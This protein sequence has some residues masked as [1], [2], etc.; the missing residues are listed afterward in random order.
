MRDSDYGTGPVWAREEQLENGWGFKLHFSH[1][2]SIHELWICNVTMNAKREVDGCNKV[3]IFV[4]LFFG[5]PYSS[6]N[7]WPSKRGKVISFQ[8]FDGPEYSGWELSFLHDR[9]LRSSVR[10][11]RRAVRK[12]LWSL[13]WIHQTLFSYSLSIPCS[14]SRLC[15]EYIFL[16]RV[17]SI[18]TSI[19]PPTTHA[20]VHT[21]YTQI[22]QVG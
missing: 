1:L 4:F 11:T 3:A 8:P 20:H 10:C 6:R 17:L 7:R 12:L 14:L 2:I 13:E 18:W 15:L 9:P 21:H 22:R 19:H 16:Q 5:L